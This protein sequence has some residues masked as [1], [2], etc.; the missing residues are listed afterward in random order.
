MRG[1]RYCYAHQRQRDCEAR[2][3]RERK[4]QRWFD[5]AKLDE[6]K[7]IQ[8]ALREVIVRLLENRIDPKRASEINRE[9]RARIKQM[10]EEE[11]AYSRS[12]PS[13]RAGED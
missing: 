2:R 11:K 1:G 13:L 8:W 4:R 6:Y 10:R 5:A 3:Q 7:A 12:T 9:I